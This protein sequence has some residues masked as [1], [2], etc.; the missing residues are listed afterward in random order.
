MCRLFI[1]AIA[2][3]IVYVVIDIQGLAKAKMYEEIASAALG[4]VFGVLLFGALFTSCYMA[5]VQALKQRL[6]YKND[7]ILLDTCPSLGMLTISKCL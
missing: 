3:F 7:Y 6:L 5:K 4:L 2:A 1:A